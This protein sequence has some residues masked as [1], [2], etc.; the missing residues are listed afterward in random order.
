MEQEWL[1]TLCWLSH[2]IDCGSW[3]GNCSSSW[4]TCRV[5][6][7]FAEGRG[8]KETLVF[9]ESCI[10]A[11]RL[12]VTKS[13]FPPGNKKAHLLTAVCPN[14]SYLTSWHSSCSFILP[15]LAI[16]V[17]RFQIS[18][19]FLK[20]PNNAHLLPLADWMQRSEGSGKEGE[21]MALSSFLVPCNVW[22]CGKGSLKG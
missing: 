20:M 18:L 4:L 2:Y 7:H 6:C 5:A 15:L 8:S 13:T 14:Q 17:K 9:E 1:S 11:S 12:P 22:G 3:Q 19:S 16:T 21:D 10:P